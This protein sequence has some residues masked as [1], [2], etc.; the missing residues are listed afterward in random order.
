MAKGDETIR[1]EVKHGG[2]TVEKA[3]GASVPEVEL[4]HIEAI[5]FLT[6]LF[7]ARRQTLSPAVR[8]WFPLPLFMDSAD[9]V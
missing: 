2:V 5:S 7:S 8:S 4:G 1:I 3:D 9:H 6:G